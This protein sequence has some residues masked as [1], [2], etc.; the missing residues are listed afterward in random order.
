[1]KKKNN[2]K[3]IQ[4]INKLEETEYGTKELIHGLIMGIIAGFILAMILL[5]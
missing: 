4:A 3:L 5:R 2:A 1:M